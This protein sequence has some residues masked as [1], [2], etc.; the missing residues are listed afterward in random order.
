MMQWT[1]AF[2]PQARFWFKVDDDVLPQLERLVY[3]VERDFVPLVEQNDKALFGYL[4]EGAEVFRNPEHK[5]YG[6]W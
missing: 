4:Y 5:T 3:R 1:Q 2:C 6:K